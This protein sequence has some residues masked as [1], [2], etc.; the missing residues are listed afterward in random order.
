MSQQVELTVGAPSLDHPGLIVIPCTVRVSEGGKHREREERLLAG[1]HD[2]GQL[3][4]FDFM[5]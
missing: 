2:Q 5:P 1:R 3:G 4:E